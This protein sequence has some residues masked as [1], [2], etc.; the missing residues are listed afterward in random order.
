[1]DKQADNAFVVA[2]TIPADMGK[3]FLFP[4]SIQFLF[5]QVPRSLDYQSPWLRTYQVTL[6]ILLQGLP[7]NLI[8]WLPVYQ[9]SCY[10]V[11][12]SSNH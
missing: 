11:T 6:I 2:L 3:E 9:V 1:M 7:G 8:T 4:L 12:W 5:Y 10:Q